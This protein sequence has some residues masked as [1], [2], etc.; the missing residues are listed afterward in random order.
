MSSAAE[1]LL[2]MAKLHEEKEKEYGEDYKWMGTVLEAMFPKG[3]TLNSEEEF[4]R[5]ALLVMMQT[6]LMRYATNFH[7]GGHED[8]LRDLGVYSALQ[9]EL[10]EMARC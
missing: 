10:D 4:G 9:A 8:S 1:R 6:K 5:M 7:N 2:A 3:L